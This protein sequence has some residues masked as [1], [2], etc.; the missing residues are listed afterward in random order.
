MISATKYET[1]PH[2][3]TVMQAVSRLVAKN[4]DTR[5]T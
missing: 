1:K 3:M 4:N 5:D 2:K